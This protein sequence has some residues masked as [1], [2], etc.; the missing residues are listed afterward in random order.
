MFRRWRNVEILTTD[1][2]VKKRLLQMSNFIHNLYELNNSCIKNRKPPTK[3]KSDTIF[4]NYY[5]PHD[6]A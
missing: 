2:F 6:F 3:K 4:Q 1:Y 5:K